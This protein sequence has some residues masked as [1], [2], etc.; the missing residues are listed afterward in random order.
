M[1]CLACKTT[2][3]ETVF[4]VTVVLISE[5]KGHVTKSHDNV[6]DKNGVR[7]QHEINFS[8]D[9]LHFLGVWTLQL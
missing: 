2:L 4:L 6:L 8:Q 5:G 1:H 9:F 7:G 3:P